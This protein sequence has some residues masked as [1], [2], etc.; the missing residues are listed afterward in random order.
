MNHET[1]GL[2]LGFL[3][4]TAF[5]L[6]L[7]ATR[8][9]VPYF[10]PLFIGLGRAVVAALVAGVLLL[11]AKETVPHKKQIIQ[12]IIVALG[13]VIGFPVLSAWAMQTVPASHGGVVL[14]ILPLTTAIVGVLISREK[15]SL[16]FWT[17]GILGAT[18]VVTYSLF[19]GVG[20]F[21]WG[22][23][24][25]LGAVIAAGI[26]YAVGGKLSREIGGWKVICWALV[27]SL[28]IILVPA[29]MK[30]PQEIYEFPSKVWISF[31]YLALVSQLFGFF[32]WNKGLALGGIA[33]VSQTQLVQPF[34]TI[35]A[36]V[37]LIGET[38]DMATI[39]FAL[40]VVVTVA[41][42]RKMPIYK[43]PN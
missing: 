16:G 17:S 32:L 5:G 18:L 10:D 40:L 14:G 41:F 37:M 20:D 42:N 27:L 24:A 25:L 8:F 26:G 36:S 38:M 30:A 6:T 1:K 39:I 2:I 13:V 12:L 28:P 21:L 31:L 15:P 7:P 33:R 4:V 43:K 22:D 3:G 9:V 29:I 35:T 23:L 19:R 34:I 11:L